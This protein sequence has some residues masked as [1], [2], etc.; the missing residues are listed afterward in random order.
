MATI[1]SSWPSSKLDQNNT[2][3]QIETALAELEILSNVPTV[4]KETE[5]VAADLEAAIENSAIPEFVRFAWYKPST[6]GVENVLARVQDIPGGLAS[7][8]IYQL[9]PTMPVFAEV[10]Y[11]DVLDSDTAVFTPSG[12]SQ[13]YEY[14]I[15][16]MTTRSTQAVDY[17]EAQ[18]QWNNDAGADYNE[19]DLTIERVAGVSAGDLDGVTY[20]RTRNIGT[21]ANSRTWARNLFIIRDYNTG[22]V[23][24]P[25]FVYTILGSLAGLTD[26]HVQYKAMVTQIANPFTSIEFE[27][28]AGNWLAGSQF[29][30][31]GLGKAGV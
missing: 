17:Y 21:T 27:A 13:D 7:D 6:G 24:M 28:G 4:H 31:L 10:I 2:I 30:I 16:I 20:H 18:L 19:Q 3:L 9:C 26:R 8:T 15:I 1:P 25:G 23:V 12:F 29:L 5:P 11:H 22:N 14:L